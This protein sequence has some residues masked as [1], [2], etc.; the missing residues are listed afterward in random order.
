MALHGV[1]ADQLG[2]A[3]G[4]RRVNGRTFVSNMLATKPLDVLMNEAHQEGEHALRRVLGPVNLVTLGIG[5][6]IGAGIFV[7]TGTVAASFAGPAIVL[8]F[9]FAGVGCVFAGLCYAEFASLIPIAGSAYTYGY[10]TLGEIFAWIIGW[11]LIIEYAFGAA[12]VASG[13]SGNLRAL[14]QSFNIFLPPQLTAPPGTLLVLYHGLWSPIATIGPVLAQ[15]GV[16]PATLPHT[17]GVIDLLAY[18]VI[19]IITTILVIG[20]RESANVNTTVVFIKVGTVLTFIAIV[21][22]YLWKHPEISAANWHPFVPPNLG[23]FGQFG[24][25]GVA[26]GAGV[27]FFAYIGFDAVSTAAQEAKNPQ[28]DMP[29]GILGSLVICTVLYIALGGMLTGVV[30]YK[31]LNTA[32][33]VAAGIEATG[34]RWGSVVVM[35]GTFAGLTT[36]MLV[37][38][39]GQSRVFY[40]MSRDGLLPEWAGRIHPRFRT[41]W[42]SSIVVGFCVALFASVLPINVLSQLTSIGTLLAFVIVCAGVWVLRVRRPDLPRPFKT[43]LVPLVPIL[44]IGISFFLMASLPL[45][46][47]LRLIVWLI[48]GMAIYFGYGRH[49]SR[50]A[51]QRKG[52]PTSG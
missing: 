17:R 36:T 14:M 7:L 25:S 10:A 52:E 2:V 49:H 30:N 15:A 33:P 4:L 45:S 8:S 12:T 27:I 46:T 11:D 37:M 24:W 41:P 28:R 50:L 39:M 29:V 16:D 42:I 18:V 21:A 48:F 34:V 35:L 43:P 38:L 40:S 9:I 32:A 6:I 20:V 44:G 26:R 22:G 5:A 51:R 13:W 1:W 3:P 31:T 19:A 23:E 47:W